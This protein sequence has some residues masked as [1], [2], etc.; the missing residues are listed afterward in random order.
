MLK[1]AMLMLALSVPAHKPPDYTPVPKVENVGRICTTRCTQS[2]P[3][4]P[5][6]PQGQQECTTTCF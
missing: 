1:T 6:G 3:C 5:R 4:C 2:C